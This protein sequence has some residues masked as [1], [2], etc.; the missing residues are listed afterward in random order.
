MEATWSLVINTCTVVMETTSSLAAI[1]K[2]A[3]TKSFTA[4]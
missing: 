3:P 4:T 2:E 1:L